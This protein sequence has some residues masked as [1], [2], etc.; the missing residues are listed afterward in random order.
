MFVSSFKIRPEERFNILVWQK[1]KSVALEGYTNTDFSAFERD[2]ANRGVKEKEVTDREL[3]IQ[4]SE[5]TL[6]HRLDDTEGRINESSNTLT[7]IKSDIG[8]SQAELAVLSKRNSDLKAA[9]QE[10]QNL[11]KD[12]ETERNSVRDELRTLRS[13]L[14]AEEGELKRVKGEIRL[15][16]S[17]IAGFVKEGRR[18][19]ALYVALSVPFAVIILWVTWSLFH[20][21]ADL[22][23]LWKT[24]SDI[25]VW[26]VFLTR[27]PF[28]LVALTILE[29]CGYLLGRFIFEVMKISRQRLN[30]S[31]LSII[32][33]EVS[34]ASAS[35]KDIGEEELYHLETQL[36]MELLR[37]HMKEY[38]SDTFQYKGTAVQAAV[39]A[40]MRKLTGKDVSDAVEDSQP[41]KT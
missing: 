23:Q 16:P 5:E 41:D 39:R 34:A 27:I 13:D 2:I 9:N 29:V 10:A 12:N 22:T 32:A 18:S 37:D 15:F 35:G 24:T 33:K 8:K 38:I 7:A 17:E 40:G 25:D 6:Q 36:K 3:T 30:L 14:A 31:K 20:S 21:A 28:V 11:L 4:K 19:V 26:T 1:L